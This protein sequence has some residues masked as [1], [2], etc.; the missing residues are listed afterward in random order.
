MD[1]FTILVQG[2]GGTRLL[3]G[4]LRTVG[5]VSRTYLAYRNMVDENRSTFHDGVVFD[6]D[7][8]RTHIVDHE[9]KVWSV[10]SW[11]SATDA[12]ALTR[13]VNALGMCQHDPELT[14]K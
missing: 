3:R 11:S 5:D 12:V 13:A 2:S 10:S 6:P 4:P 1:Y 7:G 14:G 9:G 8:F